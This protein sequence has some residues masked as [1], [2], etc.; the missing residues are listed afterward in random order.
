M[1]FCSLLC[2]IIFYGIGV[3]ARKRKDPM[4]FYSGVAVDPKII[5]DIPAYNR[6]NARMWK[7]FSVPFWLCAL[8]SIL[9]F[10]DRRFSTVSIALL[11]VGCTVGSGWLIAKYHRIL[12][13][14]TLR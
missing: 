2:A 6:E 9:T 8:C 11:V 5:S 4:H 1:T 13:K 3:W 14:Y 10:W 12:K 7:A